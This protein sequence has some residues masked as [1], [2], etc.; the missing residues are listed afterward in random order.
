MTVSGNPAIRTS[1]RA[2]L[3]LV[4]ELVLSGYRAKEIHEK[5]SENI[6]VTYGTIRNDIVRLRKQHRKDLDEKTELVGRDE[7]NA[8]LKTLRRKALTGWVEVDHV[9]STKIKGRDL[10]LVHELD[11]ELARFSG[12]DLKQDTQNVVMTVEKVRGYLD[13]IMGVVFVHVTDTQL[14]EAIIGDLARIETDAE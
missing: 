2:R 4:E 11:K 7:Y 6:S 5:L 1:T 12:V 10:K 14:R 9:G 13:R 3:R 8:R